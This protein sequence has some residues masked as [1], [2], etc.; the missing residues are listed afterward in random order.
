MSKIPCPHCKADLRDNL[1]SREKKLSDFKW[2]ISEDSK[3]IEPLVESEK[4]LDSYLKYHFCDNCGE[5]L[6]REEFDA[7][8]I[9]F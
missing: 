6:G 3:F 9:D 7:L 8:G 5:E 2:E 1:C 4:I